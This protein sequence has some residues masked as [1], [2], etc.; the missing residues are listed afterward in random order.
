MRVIELH[1]TIIKPLKAM[2]CKIEAA[3]DFMETGGG[4]GG[5]ADEGEGVELGF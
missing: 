1:E 4:A 3:L 2:I 5:H